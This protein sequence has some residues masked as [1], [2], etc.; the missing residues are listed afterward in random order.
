MS[1]E[2][3]AFHGAFQVRVV[4]KHCTFD[5]NT[6]LPIDKSPNPMYSLTSKA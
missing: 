6:E 3:V 5:K 4:R 2:A 1:P